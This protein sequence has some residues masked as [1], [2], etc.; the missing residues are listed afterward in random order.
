METD[1]DDDDDDD[2]ENDENIYIGVDHPDGKCCFLRPTNKRLTEQAD[3]NFLFG[4]AKDL[5][6]SESQNDDNVDEEDDEEMYLGVDDPGGK[7]PFLRPSDK[8]LTRE[9]DLNLLF[10]HAEDLDPL[11]SLLFRNPPPEI[12][13]D[14]TDRET[15]LAEEWLDENFDGLL[16]I[17]RAG[18]SGDGAHN[19]LVGRALRYVEIVALLEDYTSTDARLVEGLR[20]R[21]NCLAKFLRQ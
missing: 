10:G 3:L 12:S 18:Y 20:Q 11:E 4:H 6:S 16:E 21:R 13:E 14:P 19:W 7:Q 1:N 15:E 17:R 5:E 2:E 9:A 8:Q